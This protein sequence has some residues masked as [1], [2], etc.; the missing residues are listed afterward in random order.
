[1]RCP[2]RN[3]ERRRLRHPYRFGRERHPYR[4]Q[5]EAWKI[6]R[7][8]TPQ[9]LVVASGTGS[10]KTECFMV[11]ILDRL[12]RQQAQKQGRLVGVRAL[13]LYPL[14]ALIN[15]QR[16]RLRAWTHAFGR[17]IRFCLYNGNTPEQLPANQTNAHPNEVADRKTLRDAPPPILVTNATMLEYMLVRNVDAPILEHSQ[18]SLEW[19]VLD[20]A[21]TYVGSQAAELALLLR[22]VL[23]AFGVRSE[24]VRFVATSATIGDPDG[25]A[26]ERL[27]H[28]LADAAGVSADRVHLVA[29]ARAVPILDALPPR[30]KAPESLDDLSLLAA[31]ADEAQP[32]PDRHAALAAHPMARAIRDLFIAND[33]RNREG[34][35]SGMVASLAGLGR[36][37]HGAAGPFNLAQQAEVLRWLD[38]LGGTRGADGVPFLPLRAHLFHQTLSGIWACADPGCI[39]RQGTALDDP[40]WPFGQVFLEPRQHCPC[41]S[42]VYEL[43]ACDD[44][45]APHLIAVERDG[46][47]LPP[48]ARSAIDEF[49]L[50]AEPDEDH[51]EDDSPEPNDEE[52]RGRSET[53]VLVVNRPGL[54]HT[55]DELI[56]RESRRFIDQEIAGQTLRLTIQAA[57]SNG[58][59]CP[60][61]EGQDGRRKLMQESRIGAPFALGVI[62][63]TLLEFAPDERCKPGELP[64]RGRRL[65]TF[66][67]SRQGTAR[68]A[69]RLQQESERNR[70]RALVYHL[71]L[72]EGLQ[73]T[74]AEAKGLQTEIADDESLLAL[75]AE[76]AGR[77]LVE[78]RLT[79]KRARLATLTQ[80]TPIP[81]NDLA[82]HL[83]DQG[84][85]FER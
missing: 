40:D 80:P 47:L 32:A 58:F 76:P 29:G 8:E 14:N 81:F 49:E 7:Q 55:G 59:T 53:G 30:A 36:L 9:S 46:R 16:E 18:G 65:L 73:H 4:H 23:H 63:P 78:D 27:R 84:Q 50:D 74:T 37:I 24:Q 44:C 77:R 69:A 33:Q 48:Q 22:R 35:G 3:R 1:E 17:D 61:C 52:V 57:M 2:E 28:F 26:G 60:C 68:M 83:A 70:V 12:V 38:L 25:E 19:V 31:D 10:G 79:T 20:E 62:L 39:H 66:N 71:A 42:P 13:F 15:S 75:I 45:G 5:L 67:D 43:V 41:G 21:H 54:P 6:L 64:Y 82:N 56:E 11:P 85:D 72:R 51:A 34:G